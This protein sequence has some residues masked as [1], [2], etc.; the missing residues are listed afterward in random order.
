MVMSAQEVKS[1]DT[2]GDRQS[3]GVPVQDLSF[4]D[5]IH[6]RRGCEKR[7]TVERV[8][9]ARLPTE[10]GEFRI[11]GYRSLTSE[12]EFVALVK[13]PLCAEHPTLIRIHSQCMTG[14]AFG[15]IRCDCGRQ[16]QAAM[17]LIA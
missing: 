16:L 8:S 5:S 12:E 13:G 11:T 10:T 7:A 6:A 4:A 15:S 3:Y 2:R 17:K 9:E 1:T 14:D